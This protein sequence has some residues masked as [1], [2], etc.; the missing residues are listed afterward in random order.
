MPVPYANQGFPQGGPSFVSPQVI[1]NQQPQQTVGFY[2]HVLPSLMQIGSGV[3]ELI[4]G[5]PYEEALTEQAKAAAAANTAS[6][7]KTEQDAFQSAVSAVATADPAQQQA[8]KDA[9]AAKY[10]DLSS[11]IQGIGKTQIE[12]QR[13]K[14][15]DQRRAASEQ[16]GFGDGKQGSP[17]AEAPSTSAPTQA[18]GQ[19]SPPA[20]PYADPGGKSP[21]QAQN[22]SDPNSAPRD[23]GGQPPFA[24]IPP[25]AAPEQPSPAQAAA[26]T[27]GAAVPIMD[28]VKQQSM[29][30]RT[31]ISLAEVYQD[32]QKYSPSD[33]LPIPEAVMLQGPQMEAASAALQ[34]PQVKTKLSETLTEMS[35]L[36]DMVDIKAGRTPSTAQMLAGVTSELQAQ[37]IFMTVLREQGVQRP[38][39]M[40]QS[41]DLADVLSGNGTPAQI[42]ALDA[43]Y[44]NDP[45]QL[46]A[47]SVVARFYIENKT[48]TDK[49]RAAMD[50]NRVAE[51]NNKR[52]TAASIYGSDVSRQN[53]QDRISADISINNADNAQRTW[54]KKGD[55][56]MRGQE[57]EL[58]AREI[59]VTASN[60]I[61]QR[62]QKAVE[63]WEEA[64]KTRQDRVQH[65]E[66]TRTKLLEQVNPNLTPEGGNRIKVAQGASSVV[67]NYAESLDALRS[68]RINLQYEAAQVNPR[69][70][71]SADK[72]AKYDKMLAEIDQQI[73]ARQRELDDARKRA[74]EAWKAAEDSFQPGKEDKRALQQLQDI[75]RQLDESYT[76]MSPWKDPKYQD[77]FATRLGG[78]FSGHPAPTFEQFSAFQYGGSG[79]TVGELGG[80]R[81]KALYQRFLQSWESYGGATMQ[82]VDVPEILRRAARA[83]GIP[84]QAPPGT[85]IRQD[86][87]MPR[88]AR[89]PAVRRSTNRKDR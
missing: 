17:P 41:L 15:A 46:A 14:V 19:S 68:L 53:N 69:A 21:A 32:P 59:D 66:T 16:G 82:N 8:I 87:P 13:Q 36:Q 88:G 70:T 86:P 27:V 10:P 6:A 40:R 23:T 24:G 62:N 60:N 9:Y 79:F 31:L 55:W 47:D 48:N 30:Q 44:K 65:L 26:G 84:T 28:M 37:N 76:S 80:P 29:V 77:D 34:S 83:A 74:N 85:T 43:R 5:N 58:K 12:Q 39:N 54:E 45:H 50:A 67:R 61:A 64:G 51:E 20:T 3:K 73:V 63:I 57:V 33:A 89:G 35:I 56:T 78:M 2:S 1:Y 38:P 4:T 7:K 18:A 22:V 25:A 52:T 75:E 42:A 81:A 49:V 71:G 11:A 72:I